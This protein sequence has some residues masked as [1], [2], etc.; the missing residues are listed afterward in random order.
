MSSMLGLRA[1]RHLRCVR[2]SA[3]GAL[4]PSGAFSHPAPHEPVHEPSFEPGAAMVV[5]RYG[6]CRVV[7]NA[8]DQ[9]E[10]VFPSGQTKTFLSSYVRLQAGGAT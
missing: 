9:V 1:L 2:A 10:V 7:S 4:R 3:C 8:A 5:P 6:S